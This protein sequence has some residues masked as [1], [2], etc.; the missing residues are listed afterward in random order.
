VSCID[1]LLDTDDSPSSSASRCL[2]VAEMLAEV[3]RLAI[4]GLYVL[5]SDEGPACVEAA[6]ACC[7]SAFHFSRSMSCSICVWTGAE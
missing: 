7:A 4:L 3:L 2:R 6:A 1:D 5:R